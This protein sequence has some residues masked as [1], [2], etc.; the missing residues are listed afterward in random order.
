M[1]KVYLNNRIH[2]FKSM[3]EAAPFLRDNPGAEA[4]ELRIHWHAAG[5][6]WRVTS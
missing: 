2:W 4:I 5:R 1:I 3:D 6:E